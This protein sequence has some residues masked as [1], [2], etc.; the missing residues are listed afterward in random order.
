MRYDIHVHVFDIHATYPG[1][2]V[3]PESRRSLLLRHL[4]KRMYGLAGNIAEPQAAVAA[5]VD[6]WIRESG[7]DRFVLLALDR[8]HT[9]AGEP[10]LGH[11]RLAVDNDFVADWSTRQPKALFGASI[12]PF[13]KDALD[14]LDRLAARGACLVKWIPSAQNIPPD[15]PR[16]CTFYDKLARL[17]L[18]LLSHTGLEHTLPA[19]DQSLN[20]PRRLVAPLERGVTVIAA[21]CGAR[22]YLHERDCFDA[23]VQTALR[24][25]N[26]YGD[27]SGFCLPLHEAPRRRLLDNPDLASR[28]LFGSDFPAYALPLWYAPTLG[29]GRARQLRRIRNPFEKA[30]RMMRALGVPEGAFTRAEALLRQPPATGGASAG[31]EVSVEDT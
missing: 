15:S 23:W 20:D 9:P 22:M 26:L 7:I 29:L 28:M 21:H 17:R 12:H 27:L 19:F 25:R 24:H 2:Y 3:C 30:W 8:A 16:C 13:R 4:M 1:S 6:G 10:D 14:E 11:T 31:K 18:P 5:Q